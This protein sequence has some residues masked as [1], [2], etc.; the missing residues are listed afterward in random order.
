MYSDKFLIEE[1]GP[2]VSTGWIHPHNGYFAG[3]F[4]AEPAANL[5]RRYAS[6]EA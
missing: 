1:E 5:E 6:S 3:H 2:F 4:P